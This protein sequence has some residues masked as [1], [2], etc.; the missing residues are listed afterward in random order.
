MCACVRYSPRSSHCWPSQFVN[1]KGRCHAYRRRSL[2]PRLHFR[3]D[4]RRLGEWD[5]PRSR[6]AIT[7]VKSR[8]R[9]LGCVTRVALL[10]P[11]FGPDTAVNPGNADYTLMWIASGLPTIHSFRAPTLPG[12]PLMVS[13]NYN[14]QTSPASYPRPC[15]GEARYDQGFRIGDLMRD[16]AGQRAGAVIPAFCLFRVRL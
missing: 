16:I 4:G 13:R 8:S 12:S 9:Q 7:P 2:S 3:A 6:S 1:D 15:S 5:L 11:R 10:C 14:R